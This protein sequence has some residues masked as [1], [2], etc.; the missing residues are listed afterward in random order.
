MFIQHEMQKFE[1][2]EDHPER[3]GQAQKD[4]TAFFEAEKGVADGCT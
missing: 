3:Q 2:D 4:M 1:T